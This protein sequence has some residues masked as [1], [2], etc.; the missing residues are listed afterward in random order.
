MTSS[1]SQTTYPRL[2]NDSLILITAEQLK[3]TNLVFL[4]NSTLKTI[5]SELTSQVAGYDSLYTLELHKNLR[6]EEI[7]L[8]L[9]HQLDSKQSIIDEQT[10]QLAIVNRRLKWWQRGACGSSLVA[11][12]LLG[13]CVL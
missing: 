4:E 13:I 6:Y 9:K 1:F 2:I 12:V 11:L 3:A 7:K 10:K 5:N 8:D